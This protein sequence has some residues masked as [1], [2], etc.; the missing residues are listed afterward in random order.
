[1]TEEIGKEKFKI[2]NLENIDIDAI[3]EAI[4]EYIKMNDA[5]KKQR[6]FGT[7]RDYFF[8]Y[9]KVRFSV[10]P[11]MGLAYEIKNEVKLDYITLHSTK[12]IY[13]FF[14]KK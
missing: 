2:S 11:I 9:K 13:A 10:K 6:G 14:M 1:M 7:G 12:K 8:Y 3:K 5:E 4:S